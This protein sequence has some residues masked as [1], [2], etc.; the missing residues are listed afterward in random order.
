MLQSLSNKNVLVILPFYFGYQNTIKNCLELNGAKVWLIDEDVNEFSFFHRTISVYF[1]CL[2]QKILRNYYQSKFSSLPE[3]FDYVLI[4]KGST[5]TSIEIDY[6]KSKYKNA[7][8]IMY[9]WDSVSNYSHAVDVASWCNKCLTFD[10]VDAEKYGWVYRPLFY[11]PA[12]VKKV[13][14]RDIDVAYICSL[15]SDRVKLYQCI[16]KEVETKHLVFFDYLFSNRWSF[17]RQK[18]LKKNESF[19]IESRKVKFKSLPI[20]KTFDIYN[21]SKILVDFKFNQQNGLTMRSIESIGH[22]CKLIT[23]NKLIEKEDFYDP[24]NIYIYD[25]DNFEIPL[26]F[27]NSEYEELPQYIYDKYSINGWVKDIFN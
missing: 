4:I 15:H 5:L 11:N 22:K 6:L 21:R 2:Y 1:K 13:E 24:N 23:N 10:P 17:Y 27:L 9:Q 12:V 18:Y 7:Q 19:N 8:F 3:Q 20:E 26:D 25:I 16:S 14:N